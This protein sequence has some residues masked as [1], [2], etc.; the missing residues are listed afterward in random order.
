MIGCRQMIAVAV[1]RVATAAALFAGG[2]SASADDV[3]VGLTVGVAKRVVT[4]PLWVPYLTSSGNG[5]GAPLQGVH[6][7]LYARALVVSVG[8]RKIAVLAVD[9]LGYDNAILRVQ[10]DF[11]AE[12]RRQIA[13]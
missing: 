13:T 9:S 4:P 8:R 3:S 2:V 6:D 1:V 12:L 10:R 5:T 7:D 11:T